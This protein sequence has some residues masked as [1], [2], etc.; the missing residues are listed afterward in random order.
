M[1]V[2]SMSFFLLGLV[3]VTGT[4]AQPGTIKSAEISFSFPSYNVYGSIQGFNS[5]SLI[6]WDNLPASKFEGSVVVKTLKTG[7]FLRDWHLK[8]R[9]YFNMSDF[10]QIGYR[11]TAVIPEKD[12]IIVEGNLTLK[13]VTLPLR[14]VFQNVGGSLEGT[15]TLYTSDFGIQIKE[16]RALNKAEVTLRFNIEE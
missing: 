9:K 12:R 7:N 13:G 6:Y 10:P 16:E 11:S 4:R 5:S 3:L 1:T 2:K 14:I 8:G 15:A